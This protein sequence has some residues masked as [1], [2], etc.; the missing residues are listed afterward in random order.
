MTSLRP[1][2]PRLRL[3]RD[4]YN[5]LRRRVLKRDGWRC[6]NCGNSEN[7]QTH[8]IESRSRLGGDLIENLITL[9]VD[10]HREAHV[11]SK[12]HRRKHLT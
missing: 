4:A 6:Q 5:E 11:T 9:C 1:R 12:R 10:C 8:H 7:L 3:G 2:R